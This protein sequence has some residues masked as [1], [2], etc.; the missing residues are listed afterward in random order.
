MTHVLECD[1]IFL[2][3]GSQAV[4]T[5]VHMRCETGEVVGVLGKNGAGK[6]CLMKIVFG[7]LHSEYKSVRIDGVVCKNH[8]IRK[9][10]RY[11]PQEHFIPPFLNT[12]QCLDMYGVKQQEI[13]SA[14]PT[15][16][17]F[18]GLHM[19]ELPEGYRRLLE[20]MLVLKSPSMFCLL[21]EPFH[22]LIP[23]H[24]EVLKDVI[25]HERQKK[26]ILVT[27]RWHRHVT[28][29]ADRLYLLSG[30]RMRPIYD[31]ESFRTSEYPSRL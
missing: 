4:L 3:F 13:L 16:K 15:I 27:D 21:D 29:L 2:Q 14:F 28:S 6:S 24:I 10:V 8:A 19:G 22:G 12:R 26:G 9:S 31:M 11:L 7:A 20:V 30:G 17:P 18:M 1:S 5:S 23:S 25:R